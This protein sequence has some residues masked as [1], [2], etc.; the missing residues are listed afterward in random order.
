[1]EGKIKVKGKK[2]VRMNLNIKK[3]K[4]E[5]INESYEMIVMHGDQEE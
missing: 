1:V 3:D 2:I 4:I 5:I